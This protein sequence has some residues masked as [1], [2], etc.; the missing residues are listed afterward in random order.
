MNA[1]RHGSM[2]CLSLLKLLFCYGK[3]TCKEV[4][5]LYSNGKY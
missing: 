1:G 5:D 4:V 3:F 2:S